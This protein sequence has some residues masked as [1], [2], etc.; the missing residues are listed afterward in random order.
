PEFDELARTAGTTLNEEERVAAYK[1]IQRVLIE[2]GPVII[3]YFFAQLGAIKKEYAGFTMKAFPGR[4][5]L[6]TIQRSA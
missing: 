3:P 5:D 2:R 6:A 1:E 4:S